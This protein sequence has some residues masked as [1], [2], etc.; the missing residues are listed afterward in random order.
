MNTPLSSDRFVSSSVNNR[1]HA[2][3]VTVVTAT[4]NLFRY[5][6]SEYFQQCV[7]SVRTQNYPNIEHLIIDGGSDD[8]TLDLLEKYSQKGWIRYL[9]EPDEGIYNAMNKGIARACGK[10]IAFLNSDDYWHDSHAVEESIA[11]LEAT[12]SVFSYAEC[13]VITPDGEKLFDFTP[14]IGTFFCRHP[15]SHQTM[16]TLRQHMLQMGGFDESFISAADYDFVVRSLMKGSKSV[17][18]PRNIA[19]FRTGGF[20]NDAE[21]C[22]EEVFKVLRKNFSNCLSDEQIGELMQFKAPQNFVGWITS[23]V[24]PVTLSEINRSLGKAAGTCYELSESPCS[25]E[26]EEKSNAI[27]PPPHSKSTA[28]IAY[29]GSF[30]LLKLSLN[31]TKRG[32][33]C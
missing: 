26:T 2:P 8:G 29:S 23:F 12:G 32:L 31:H 19:T 24:H 14:R 7:D 21:L 1:R 25:T 27:A 20:S 15:F 28:S 30:P 5:G 9:S 10:Y 3:I 18:I 22:R 33:G 17:Q 16:F 11:A 13:S 4:F 6:R